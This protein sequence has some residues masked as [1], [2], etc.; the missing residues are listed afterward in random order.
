MNFR[1]WAYNKKNRREAS[2]C[3][4]KCT[5]A[6]DKDVRDGKEKRV[7]SK[8]VPACFFIVDILYFHVLDYL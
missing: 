7:E 5:V 2:Y 3:R 6:V 4:K 8:N 1:S